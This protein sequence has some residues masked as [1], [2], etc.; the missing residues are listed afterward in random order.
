MLHI[1][2]SLVH[3]MLC[4]LPCIF[5]TKQ[6][7]LMKYYSH[8]DFIEWSW[9]HTHILSSTLRS[10]VLRQL[11]NAWT[12]KLDH[13]LF[14]KDWCSKICAKVLYFSCPELFT[15]SNYEI[16]YCVTKVAFWRVMLLIWFKQ[17]LS[18]SENVKNCYK[19]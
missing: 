3:R 10:V 12:A 1:K 2:W 6:C 19:C 9:M 18:R 14:P 17:I 4:Y 5:S 13:M 16:P 7:K 11:R 15:P 8:L